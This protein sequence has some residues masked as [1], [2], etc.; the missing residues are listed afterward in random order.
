[1]KI[2]KVLQLQREKH[3]WSQAELAE[4]LNISRQSVSKWEQEVALPSFANVVAISDL[5][6]ISLDD[7]IRGDDELMDKLS[8]ND[9]MRPVTKIVLWAMALAVGIYILLQVFQVSASDAGNWI[10]VPL[11]FAFVGFL[12]TIN[13]RQLNRAFS[14]PAIILG[15]IVLTL[16][17]IPEIYGFVHGIANGMWEAYQGF[18]DSYYGN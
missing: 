13:W 5:F 9:K 2:G 18:K 16:V 1:M 11:F 12:F 17:L 10:E 7:L 15:I 8:R 3:H 6:K 4:K 14:K